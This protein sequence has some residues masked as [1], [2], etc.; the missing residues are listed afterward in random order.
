[1]A[2]D[3]FQYAVLQI[4]PRVERNEGFNA[5]VVVFCRRRQ[6]LAARTHVDPARLAALAP[7]LSPGDVEPHL[8]TIEALAAGDP[9]GGPLHAESQSE[10]FG[11]ITAA[12]ST[13]LQAGPVHTG[14]T[15]DPAGT[16]ERLYEQ[17]VA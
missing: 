9:A 17:L 1:M 2:P 13:I 6:F 11:W 10:R 3:E 15:D 4:V 14:V 5:G 16:L 12:A 7:D 8:A